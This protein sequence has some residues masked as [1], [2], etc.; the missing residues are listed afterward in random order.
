MDKWAWCPW[1]G[2]REW[3]KWAEEEGEF[4]CSHC[5]NVGKFKKPKEN[6]K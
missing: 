5:K 6:E 2:V 1:C 3:F 4:L